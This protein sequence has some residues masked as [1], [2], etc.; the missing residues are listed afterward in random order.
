MAH[1]G[2][3]LP[4]RSSAG[5]LVAGV[6]LALLLVGCGAGGSAE[7]PAQRTTE[8]RVLAAPDPA[9]PAVPLAAPA[10]PSDPPR[11]PFPL[12]P[13]LDPATPLPAPDPAGADGGPALV[14]SAAGR[15]VVVHAAPSADAPSVT[16]PAQTPLGS[17]RVFRVVAEQDAWVQVLLPGRPLGASGWVPRDAVHLQAVPHRLVVER[18]EQRLTLY[19]GGAVVLSAPVVVGRDATPTPLGRF[20]VTDLLRAPDPD[21][22]FGPYAFGLSGRSEVLDTFAGG[23]GQLAVHGTNRPDLLGSVAS[24]GCVRVANDVVTQLVGLLPL[25]TPVDVVP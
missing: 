2:G 18:G 13:V 3:V 16:F 1:P 11:G 8:G 15:E 25:G 12:E 20:F 21:G 17:D 9:V 14:A 5:R 10:V 7:N 22:A 19:E 24:N 23:D 4:V 6:A